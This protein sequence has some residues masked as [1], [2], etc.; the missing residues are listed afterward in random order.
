MAALYYTEVERI[1]KTPRFKNINYKSLCW[2]LKKITSLKS[3]SK[4]P[5]GQ[6]I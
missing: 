6:I 2:K 5:T 3:E 1:G 4:E